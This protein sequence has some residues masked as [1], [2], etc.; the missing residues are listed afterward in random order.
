MGWRGGETFSRH[1]V[2]D[3]GLQQHRV[4]FGRRHGEGLGRLEQVQ[5]VGLRAEVQL[6]RLLLHVDVN[7]V[8][9]APDAL[10]GRGGKRKKKIK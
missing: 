7:A 5:H 3:A 1:D 4:A 9:A 6:G 8:D 2:E 10:E